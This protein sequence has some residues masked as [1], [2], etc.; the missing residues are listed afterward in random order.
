MLAEYSLF[1]LKYEKSYISSLLDF[2]QDLKINQKS[3][4]S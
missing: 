2:I 4:T 1:F 3:M